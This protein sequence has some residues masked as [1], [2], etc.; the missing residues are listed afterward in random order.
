MV[1]V[2]A[3]VTVLAEARELFD[4]FRWR[5]CADT[6]TKADARQPLD[7]EALLLLGQAGFLIG[8]E[9]R[10]VTACARAYQW[11]LDRD[12][13]RGAVRAAFGAGF[14]LDTTGE[15]V[16]AGAWAARARDLVDAQQL[17]GA[18][19]GF[20]LAQDAHRLMLQSRPAEA[21]A[22][23]REGERV[24]LAAR[25]ADVLVLSRMSIAF[26]LLVQGRR[27]EAIRVLDEIMVAVSSDETMPAIVGLSY[28]SAIA[29]CLV[30]RDITRARA[31][32]ATLDRW[33]AARPDLVPFRGICLV[34]RAHMSALGGDWRGAAEEAL[35]AEELLRG[36]QAGAAAY[37]LG[38][39]CRLTGD[40]AG[41]AA[42][43]RRANSLGTQPEPGLARLRIAEGRPA[44]AETTLR[45]LCAEP[46]P[47][48][49]RVELLAALVEAQLSLGD[50][51]GAA[52]S[53][54]ELHDLVSGLDAP[55]LLGFAE[56]ADGAVLLAGGRP[57]EALPALARARAIWQDLDLP[58]P[59]AQVRVMVGRCLRA[60]GDEASA[61][62]EFEAARECFDRLGA[63]P[64]V[65]D[66]DRLL[67]HAPEGSAG[68]R[69]GGLTDREV[70]VVRLVAAGHTN[71]LIAGELH[72]SEKTVARHLANIYAKLDV[73]SRAAATAYAYNH[74]LV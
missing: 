16:R 2:D 46:R 32:T 8:E 43:Y 64:D 71:R 33:C 14:V 45:R 62:L 42:H 65:A 27:A 10:A 73:P 22:V 63:L 74:G 51:P 61:V 48:E 53:A 49:D 25:D 34:H 37:Q 19:A 12:D 7:G 52:A 15:A 1:R 21:L 68:E 39:L 58:H 3:G 55:L 47:P 40:S 4:A 44:V 20:L 57:A 60:L 72:L 50:P 23:A 13:A 54:A 18:E 41:A 11:F 69:A 56:H 24:G 26:A 66:V 9:E 38:E 31:W 17:G 29:S 30:V 6:L 67:A 5:Q 59:C 28:C 70:Q 35:R 36:P